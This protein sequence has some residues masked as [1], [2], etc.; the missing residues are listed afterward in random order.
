VHGIQ[1]ADRDVHPERGGETG[2]SGAEERPPHTTCA[3]ADCQ[4]PDSVD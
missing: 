1:I 2:Q 3:G 4:K